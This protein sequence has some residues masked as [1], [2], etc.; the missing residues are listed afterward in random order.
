MYFRYFIYPDQ[1]RS[2]AGGTPT[3]LSSKDERTSQSPN[4]SHGNP[5][6]T[7]GPHS[8]SSSFKAAKTSLSSSSSSS[9]SKSSSGKDIKTEEKEPK[10][11]QEGQ[12]PTMETHGMSD[13][14]LHFC[15]SAN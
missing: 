12:K 14:M 7:L 15:R 1:R 13:Q 9:V 8:S 2:S 6:S 3:N 4:T 11:K 5:Q 10:V